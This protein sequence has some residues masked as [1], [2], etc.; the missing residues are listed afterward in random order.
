MRAAPADHDFFNRRFAGHARFAFTAVSTMLDLEVA[1]FA[2]GIH[3]IGDGLSAGGDCQAQNFLQGRVQFAQLGFGQRMG[4]AARPDMSAEQSF[5]GIDVP[6]AVQQLL[7]EQRG[8][9]R[10]FAG[11]E[12]PSEFLGLDAQRLCARAIKPA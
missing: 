7:V 5:I 10:R 11:M 9:D 2:I 3:V 4:P 6:H 1:R 12:K 8:F